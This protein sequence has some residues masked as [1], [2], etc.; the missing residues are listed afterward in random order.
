MTLG[1]VK[2]QT[3]RLMFVQAADDYTADDISKLEK[4]EE[5]KDYIANM[6]G[7]INRCLAN[8]EGRDVLPVKRAVLSVLAGEAYGGRVRYAL[9]HVLP[10][11]FKVE[12]VAWES[13]RG[14]YISTVRYVREGDSL[15]LSEISDKERYIIL[16]RPRVARVNAL[17]DNNTVLDIPEHI[18][19]L[20]PYYVKSELYR[21][22]EPDEAQEAR[23]L[24]ETG[25]AEI[26]YESE[27]VQ[28]KVES[29]YAMGGD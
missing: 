6:P 17:T 21:I 12:R 29:V 16:Y 5:C 10:D 26:A 25:L 13:E 2:M 4:D 7:A 23:N 19:A 3:L 8:L 14:G 20:I 22:D 28:T 18:A 1:E 11:L 15:M 9:S 27:G 24:Y